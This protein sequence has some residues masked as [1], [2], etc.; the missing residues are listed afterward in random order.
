VQGALHLDGKVTGADY[1]TSA[2]LV[3]QKELLFG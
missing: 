3:H 1:F 2:A